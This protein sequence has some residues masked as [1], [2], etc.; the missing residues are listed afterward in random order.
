MSNNIEFPFFNIIYTFCIAFIHDYLQLEIY[1]YII[2][3]VFIV[4]LIFTSELHPI[5]TTQYIFTSSAYITN[6]I[7]INTK[8]NISKIFPILLANI[9]IQIS[10]NP[11]QNICKVI[12]RNNKNY[13]MQ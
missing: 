6:S 4:I 12:Y 7:S 10:C 9:A 2:L 8:S 11:Y 1:I 3:Q 13:K 5:F